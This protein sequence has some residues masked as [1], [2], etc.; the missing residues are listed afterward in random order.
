MN[1]F[2]YKLEKLVRQYI[3]KHPKD[4][5]KAIEDV[6]MAMI[7][8]FLDLYSGIIN[9]PEGD[10]EG[11]IYRVNDFFNA[12]KQEVLKYITETNREAI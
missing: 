12:C 2:E 7:H 10:L 3:N 1:D 4:L 9:I 8:R 5:D 6:L 11:K